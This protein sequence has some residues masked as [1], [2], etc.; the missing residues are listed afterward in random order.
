MWAVLKP[1]VTDAIIT[2]LKHHA[3][4]PL[5]E[6]SHP[7]LTVLARTCLFSLSQQPTEIGQTLPQDLDNLPPFSAQLVGLF[8]Q[9]SSSAR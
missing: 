6:P 7:V 9:D 5:Q 8:C 2:S 1:V 3:A 4:S